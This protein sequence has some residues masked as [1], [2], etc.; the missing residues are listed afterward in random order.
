[1][2]IT[3]QNADEAEQQQAERAIL[4]WQASA[5]NILPGQVSPTVLRHGRTMLHFHARVRNENN[6]YNPLLAFQVS[7]G[8]RGGVG[9]YQDWD[10]VKHDWW[11]TGYFVYAEQGE[12]A[13]LLPSVKANLIHGVSYLGYFGGWH[14]YR[15]PDVDAEYSRTGRPSPRELPLSQPWQGQA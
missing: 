15:C 12:Q 11:E 14:L 6:P 7:C 8:P 13:T 10:D 2:I 9:Y 5:I 3:P 1:M 4:A